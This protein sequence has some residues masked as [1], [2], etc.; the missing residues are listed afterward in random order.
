MSPTTIATAGKLESCLGDL[1]KL[2]LLTA[3]AQQAMN[4]AAERT[5]TLQEFSRLVEKDITLAVSFLKLANSPFFSGGRNVD[6]LEQAVV[7][8]GL[9]ECQNLIVAVSMR[10]L[11]NQADPVTKAHCSVLWQHSFL[12]ACFCRRLNQ[13]LNLEYRGEEFTAGLLH[14]LGRILLAL[15][16]PRQFHAIDPMD[17]VED[18]QTLERE[19]QQ[20]ETD[21][22]QLGTLYAQDNQMPLAV[23]TAIRFHHMDEEVTSHRGIVEL[24]AVADHLA[25]YMQ[26]G[27]K[28][29]LYDMDQNPG[30]QSLAQSW[31]AEKVRAFKQLT[32]RLMDE[33]AS[34]AAHLAKP[35]K[36]KTNSATRPSSG[37]PE[38]KSSVWGN[39][40][41][42]LVG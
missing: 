2:P 5:A 15:T 11:F 17:F 16:I 39:V 6:S 14:D 7:R 35:A 34:I 29:E 36:A 21:H 26:R 31:P 8:L 42:W 28:T 37:D 10:N 22:C 20:L 12:T 4:L 1:R 19:R 33:T 41:S 23:V 18:A 3:T 38:Q 25:N 40:R 30:F 27:Q 24:V 9:R 13:E 32:P